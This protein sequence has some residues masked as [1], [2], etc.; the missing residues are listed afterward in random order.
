M[1]RLTGQWRLDRQLFSADAISPETHESKEKVAAVTRLRPHGSTASR[2][3][4][5]LDRKE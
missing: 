5:F 1:S 4:A 3:V 2:R